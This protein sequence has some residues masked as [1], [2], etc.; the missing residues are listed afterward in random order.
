MRLLKVQKIGDSLVINLPTEILR[1]LK[2]DEGDS[3]LAIETADGIGLIASN[4]EFE[5]G[6]EAYHK[7]ESKYKSALQELAQ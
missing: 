4:S 5:L 1:K 2:V 6:M 3:I 7:V